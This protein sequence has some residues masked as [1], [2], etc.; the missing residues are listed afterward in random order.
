[1]GG[2]SE[3]SDKCFIVELVADDQNFPADPGIREV[4]FNSAFDSVILPPCG[5]MFAILNFMP[6]TA[7]HKGPGLQISW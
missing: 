1:M 5:G 4:L 7:A 2:V 6:L 3:C